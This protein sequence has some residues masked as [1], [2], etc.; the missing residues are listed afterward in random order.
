[1]FSQRIAVIGGGRWARAIVGSLVLLPDDAH[2]TVHTRSSAAA[3]NE[4]VRSRDLT[5]HVTVTTAQP[6]FA[7]GEAPNAIIVANA[8][9]DHERA[10]L[11]ALD[12]G[13]PVLVEKPV[14]LTAA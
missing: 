2:I 10:A 7:A 13:I 11:R 3:M 9:S 8:A 4:W 14:A 1:M 5:A 12:S 6:A